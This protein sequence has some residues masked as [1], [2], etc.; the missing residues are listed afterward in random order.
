MEYR[1]DPFLFPLVTE[2]KSRWEKAGLSPRQETSFNRVS[3]LLVALFLTGWI[4]SIFL[5]PRAHLEAAEPVTRITGALTRSPLASD[6]PTEA[7]FVTDQLVQS[8]SASYQREFG[9]ASGAVRVKVLRPGETL[10]VPENLPEGAQVE[11]QPTQGTAGSAAAPGATQTP[12]VWN[13][14][15]KM[16]KA[17]R[18]A[19]NVSVITLVPLTAKQ[20]GR[21]G[22]YRIGSWPFERGG[23]PKPVYEPPPG[24]VE[25]TPKNMNLWISEH[26][27]LKDFLTKGQANVWPKYVALQPKVLDKVELTIQE[28]EKMGHK[29]DNIFVVSAFR[30][31]EY[32]AGGGNTAGRGALSRHMY[33]DAVDWCVDNDGDGRMDDLNGDG[34]VTVADGRVIGEAAERVERAHPDMIG[35]IGIYTPTG[36]HSGFVHLDTRGFRARW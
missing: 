14:M 13:V 4:Y 7:A 18:P 10:E 26:I 29:V 35:G 20:N 16:A 17:L 3:L 28:L 9:M 31:P 22:T 11:L 1:D 30:T 2:P 8:F 15:L 32:N 23:A 19:S 36:A 21:I 12:G 33:G 5:A 24:F 6:A 34:R 27:Q 25:V